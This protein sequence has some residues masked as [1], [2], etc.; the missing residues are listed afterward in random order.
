MHLPTQMQS[1]CGLARNANILN[2][3][4]SRHHFKI[5][6]KPATLAPTFLA[7]S[8]QVGSHKYKNI[9]FHIYFYIWYIFLYCVY[10]MSHLICIRKYRSNNISLQVYLGRSFDIT[11]VYI[12]PRIYHIFF[13]ICSIYRNTNIRDYINV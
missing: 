9:N 7:L 5:S 8:W 1:L 3:R 2:A 12:F 10:D 6:V 13:I 11:L 4:C